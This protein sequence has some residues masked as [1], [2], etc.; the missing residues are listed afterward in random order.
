MQ[1]WTAVNYSLHRSTR[2]VNYMS[3]KSW[4]EEGKCVVDIHQCKLM[5]GVMLATLMETGG[6]LILVCLNSSFIIHFYIIYIIL[7][8]I[9]R[10]NAISSNRL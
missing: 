5:H 3:P 10:Y 8:K 1:S 2:F 9:S 7:F 4:S 6:A